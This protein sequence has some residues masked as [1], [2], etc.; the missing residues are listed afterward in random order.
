MDQ[1][2]FIIHSSLTFLKD[3][4]TKLKSRSVIG[5]FDISLLTRELADI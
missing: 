1:R 4:V 5:I 3:V 2:D